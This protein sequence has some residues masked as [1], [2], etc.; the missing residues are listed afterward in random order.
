MK[1]IITTWLLAAIILIG[2]SFIVNPT[3]LGSDKT[4]P[5]YDFTIDGAAFEPLAV[6]SYTAQLTNDGRT[7]CLTFLGSSVKD[8]AG[9]IYPTKLQ[10]DYTFKPETLGEVNVER[11]TYDYNNLKY[12]GMAENAFVSIIKM[13]KNA[14]G[15][16]FTLSADI[17]CKVKKNHII[18]EFVP[19]L[20][21]R[22]GV[23]NIIVNSPVL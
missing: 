16:S 12:T 4:A 23:Q 2:E 17:F 19:V 10:I 3:K 1:R 22:G 5:H 8:N 9:N 14:D 6:N 15:K 20:A 18:E 7:V 21:I 13:K 11:V